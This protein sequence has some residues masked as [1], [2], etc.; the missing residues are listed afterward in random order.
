MNSRTPLRN[1]WP[2][3][4][5]LAL[6]ITCAAALPVLAQESGAPSA[7]SREAIDI[8]ADSMRHDDETGLITAQ[9][10]VMITQGDRLTLQADRAEYNMNDQRVKAIG[11]INLR[12]DEDTFLSEEAELDLKQGVGKLKEANVDF[13]GPGGHARAASMERLDND[14]FVLEKATYTNCDCEPA[15]WY[16]RTGRVD[17]D[18]K[19]NQATGRDVTLFLKDTPIAFTPW[20]RQPV[21]RIRQS[22]FL[23]PSMRFSGSAGLEM[24]VPYYWNIAPERDATI[25]LHP[26]SRRGTMG[27]LQYRYLGPGYNGIMETHDIYDSVDN[28]FRG[29]HYFD[30]RHRLNDWRLRAHLERSK[31]RDFTKD[32][33]QEIIPNS[34]HNLESLLR[35]ER[36]ILNKRGFTA[37]E[38]GMRW[39]QDLDAPNDQRTVQRLP[40][41]AVTDD[42]P[43]SKLGQY[44]KLRSGMHFDNFYQ[45]EGN[46][47]QRLDLAP[48]LHYRTPLNIGRF[49]AEMGVRETAYWVQGEPSQAGNNKENFRSREASLLNLRLD[50]MMQKAYQK[51]TN[52]YDGFRHTIEPTVQYV[53]NTSSRQSDFPNYDAVPRDF[54]MT[55]LF[56]PN[57]FTGI[58]RLSN[59]QWVSAGLN[60]R[61][62]GRKEGGEIK[63]VGAFGIGQ[64][65]APSHNRDLQENHAFSDIVSAA[66]W[67]FTDHWSAQGAT[68]YNP[69][70]DRFQA[71]DVALAYTNKRQDT[72]AMGYHFNHTQSEDILW[73][74]QVKLRDGWKWTQDIDYSIA[75]DGMKSWRSGILYEHDCWSFELSGGRQLSAE[76]SDHGGGWV[77]FFITFRGLGGY[78]INS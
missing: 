62:L 45:M 64:R 36:L 23:T 35:A 78:G 10:H 25:S 32:F 52:G 19:A 77:G 73:N 22:G 74:S 57:H 20:M 30:H 56:A 8:E 47:A 7:P 61:L 66:E 24:D 12:W 51:K 11:H 49:T 42:R 39:Y 15:P 34:E 76:T 65:W 18:M 26:T 55:S 54:T 60:T 31:T 38:S 70:W 14:H 33:Q 27:K 63:K 75:Q 21:R 13:S 44:W 58:D 37:F 40:Y 17:I 28:E 48:A 2:R 67:A 46:A 68:R 71:S 29:L 43:A 9:G 72:F 1:R 53:L 3:R 50:T 69:H 4:S 5:L 41:F 6:S 16:L 59:A